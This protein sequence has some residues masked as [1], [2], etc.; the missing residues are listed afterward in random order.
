[1]AEYS[2]PV[3]NRTPFFNTFTNKR[4]GNV[5]RN[6]IRPEEDD[7]NGLQ[8]YP[9]LRGVLIKKPPMIPQEEPV[10]H[11]PITP[12][13]HFQQVNRNLPD[14]VR[15]EPLDEETKAALRSLGMDKPAP[16]PAPEPVTVSSPE[17]APAPALVSENDIPLLERLI[18]DEK[19]ASVYY[20][21]LSEIAPSDDLA[22]ALKDIANNCEVRYQQYKQIL[23]T[24]HGRAFEA[25]D[26]PV[27]T[28]IAFNPGIEMALLE[29]H[30]ILEAM[31]E[32]IGCYA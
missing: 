11:P 22:I 23:Q 20:Q 31:S 17:S 12:A 10:T 7:P 3:H 1:M 2:R 14:G 25:V 24:R 32:L 28:T 13:E 26:K 30:K 5:A 16:E 15:F 6:M 9:I 8:Y 19:N 18:Q 29:E 4:M 27:N 21:Y